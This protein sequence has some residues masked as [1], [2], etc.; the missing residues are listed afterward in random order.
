MS[1]ER[2]RPLVLHVGRDE[3]VIRRRYETA[4][5]VNDILIALWFIAG[6]IMF[7]SEA[8]STAGT[9][10]FLVGS[11]ELLVRPVIR[12]GRQLHIRRMRS[13]SPGSTGEESSQDF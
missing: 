2:N 7:F 9:W 6:S 3:L 8:W 1:E 4:S 11:V 5:I 13:S 12:L 10:C